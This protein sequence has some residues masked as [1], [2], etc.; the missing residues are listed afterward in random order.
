MEHKQEQLAMAHKQDQKEFLQPTLFL[1]SSLWHFRITML[2][3]QK[4]PETVC[5]LYSL[6][7]KIYGGIK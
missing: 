5:W 7:S 4:I 1:S 6:R 2:S 3:D